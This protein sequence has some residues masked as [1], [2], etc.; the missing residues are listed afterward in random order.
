MI[1][2]DGVKQILIANNTVYGVEMVNGDRIYSPIVRIN[3]I[4]V[5]CVSELNPKVLTHLRLKI[6][7]KWA[8]TKRI[9]REVVAPIKI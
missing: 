3:S 7:C 9:C 8:R 2:K 4:G 1:N 5:K 6:N